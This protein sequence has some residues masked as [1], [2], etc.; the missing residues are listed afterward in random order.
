MVTAKGRRGGEVTDDDIRE[1]ARAVVELAR[2]LHSVNPAPVYEFD[3][4]AIAD[5]GW[6]DDDS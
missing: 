2:E 5:V 4:D 1:I 3:I 6:P